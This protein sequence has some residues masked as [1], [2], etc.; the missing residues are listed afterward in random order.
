MPL[1]FPNQLPADYA[2]YQFKLSYLQKYNP[3][4]T[5][6]CETQEAGQGPHQ[7]H[8][9]PFQWLQQIKLHHLVIGIF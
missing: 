7:P 6:S 8:I 4:F 3:V 1:G 9:F 2:L 5:N